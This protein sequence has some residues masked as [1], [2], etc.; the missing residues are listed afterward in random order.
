M[1]TA[2]HGVGGRAV[3]PRTTWE[4]RKPVP[5]TPQR[6]CCHILSWSFDRF[7]LKL[8]STPSTEW[9]MRILWPCVGSKICSTCHC[10]S[11]M[12]VFMLNLNW[13]TWSLEYFKIHCSQILRDRYLR[14]LNP[15]EDCKPMSVHIFSYF[16]PRT[17]RMKGW[18]ASVWSNMTTWLI[19]VYGV[20]G[21]KGNP[22]PDVLVESP[23]STG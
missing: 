22:G 8:P 4:N 2:R 19:R 15:Q 10:C 21:L 6:R 17:W 7:R 11:Q 14:I 9:F 18:R 3:Y 12:L 5:N 20:Y 23:T 1:S 13:K 16:P